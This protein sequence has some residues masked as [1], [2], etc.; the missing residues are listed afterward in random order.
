[1]VEFLLVLALTFVFVVL[2]LLGFIKAGS[3]VY[4]LEQANVEALLELVV[5]GKASESDW[6]VFLGVPIRHDPVLE[7]VQERCREITQAHYIG[8]KGKLFTKEGLE[9]LQ[10]LLAELKANRVPDVD[11]KL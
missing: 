3:P 1:M 8:A 5:D 6:D 11:R 7:A 4:R 9:Q 10:V 2:V